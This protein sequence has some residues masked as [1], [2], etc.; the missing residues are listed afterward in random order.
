VQALTSCDAKITCTTSTR[1]VT[2]QFKSQFKRAMDG[3]HTQY[4]SLSWILQPSKLAMPLRA[5]STPPP[6]EP[7]ERGQA[8]YGQW[9]KVQGKFKV[10]SHMFSP[11]ALDI[12]AFKMSHSDAPDINAPA[13]QLV[14][15]A[16]AVV[17]QAAR[18]RSSSIGRWNVT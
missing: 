9:M 8:P 15:V 10:Q 6:C 13:I 4:A 12:A 14:A 11:V 7:R 5:T 3:K 18:A 1:T 17:L 2:G 16:P